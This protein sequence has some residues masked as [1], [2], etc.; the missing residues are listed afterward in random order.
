MSGTS[1]ICGAIENFE[2]LRELIGA[3]SVFR[4]LAVSAETGKGLDEFRL[5]VF[6]L[7]EVIRIYTKAPGK[8]P[9]LN[10][11]YVLKRGATVMEAA[12]HVHKDFAELLKFARAWGHG[13][14]E[15]QMVQRDYVLADGDVIELHI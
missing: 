8:K 2:A 11:P 3:S 1:A 13:K 10:A 15:G 7:L 5:A 12:Q 6:D 9:D 14:F 4:I